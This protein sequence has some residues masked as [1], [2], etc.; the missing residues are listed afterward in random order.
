M[1]FLVDTSNR[2]SKKEIM[3]DLTM[4]GVLF[5][6]TLDKLGIIN[7]LLGGQQSNN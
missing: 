4:K 7:R 6:D 2:S 1:N 5:K 3:D